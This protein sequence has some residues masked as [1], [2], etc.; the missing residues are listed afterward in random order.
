[1]SWH[2]QI[3]RRKTTEGWWYE[4]VEA[5]GKPFG[6]TIEGIAPGSDTRRGLIQMLEMML[7]DAR[8]Y[9]TITGD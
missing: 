8:K 7:N 9:R 6:E 2:Y 4:I 1:M 3:R 5:Y